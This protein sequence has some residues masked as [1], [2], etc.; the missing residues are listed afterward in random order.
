M[1]LLVVITLIA[2]VAVIV[3]AISLR[4]E[5][6][7]LAGFGIITVGAGAYALLFKSDSREQ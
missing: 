6:Y 2:V 7:E 5:A 3:A 4:G 1:R